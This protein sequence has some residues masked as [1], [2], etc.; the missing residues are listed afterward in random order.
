MT[1]NL[2]ALR[3]SPNLDGLKPG[4][5]VARIWFTMVV[6]AIPNLPGN[7]GRESRALLLRRIFAV[8]IRTIPAYLADRR[9]CFAIDVYR[10]SHNSLNLFAFIAQT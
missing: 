1:L 10:L 2:K 3:G 7:A 4:S 6:F 9:N 8:E 5:V